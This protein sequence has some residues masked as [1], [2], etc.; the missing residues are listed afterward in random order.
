[1]TEQYRT[2]V[3]T[4]L[5][6]KIALRP[7]AV[8]FMATEIMRDPIIVRR[9]EP[10]YKAWWESGPYKNLD[11]RSMEGNPDAPLCTV[12]EPDFYMQVA[13]ELSRDDRMALRKK[14]AS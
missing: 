7:Q 12:T 2:F 3:E 5:D 9:Y 6:A 8:Y 4:V 1:M 10:L 11:V 13:Q 14:Y